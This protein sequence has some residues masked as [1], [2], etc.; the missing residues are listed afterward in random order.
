M[1]RRPTKRARRA[2]YTLI[3]VMV[4]VA[5]LTVGAMSILALNAAA[6]RGNMAARELSTATQV[7]SVWLER[8][9]MDA[10]RFRGTRLQRRTPTALTN[11]YWLRNVPPVGT[12]PTWFTPVVPAA[13]TFF[14]NFDFYGVGTNVAANQHYCTN[15]R[16]AW[17]HDS[18]S[19]RADV[20]VWWL[21]RSPQAVTTGL[22]SCAPGIDPNTLSGRAPR[23]IH[24]VQASTVVRWTP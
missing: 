18:N 19:I 11:T 9:Q 20:R 5:V 6:I 7:A 2:G 12:A 10:T 17:V 16:L 24:V 22:G 8:L 15:I 13:T 3:E 21:R 23:D 4:A 1:T 14:P